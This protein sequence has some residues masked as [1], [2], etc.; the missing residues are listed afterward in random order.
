MPKVLIITYYWPPSGGSSVLRWL[1]FT[2]YLR[3]FGWEPIIYTPDNPE[4]QEIDE[5]LLKDI[6]E[7]VEVIKT[8]IWEPYSIYKWL[9]GRKQSDRLGVALMTNKKSSR[10]FSHISLWIRSNLFIP[11]PRRFWVKPSVRVLGAYL[12]AHPVD[13]IVT[14]G[15]PHTMH[16]IGLGIKKKMGIKWV[17]DFRDPWTNIDFYRDLLLTKAADHYHKKLE[18]EVLKNADCVVTVS[19][20][21]AEELRLLGANRIK[22]ISNGFDYESL[23]DNELVDDGKFTLMHLG[24]IPQSRNPVDLWKVLADLVKM[25]PAFTSCLQIKLI[26]KID[27]QVIESIE[28]NALIEYVKHES[29][30]PHEQTFQQLTSASVLLLLINDTPNAKGILTNKFY[31]YLSAHRP[32]LTLGPA[33]DGDASKILAVTGAGK[34]FKYSDTKGLKSHILT[35]FELYSQHNLKVENNEIDRFSRKNLTRE[36]SELLNELIA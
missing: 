10:L 30:I 34:I 2:K 29:F 1:K 20:S 4:S 13:A 3:E 6:P 31:E 32:I 8:K 16:L 24:S 5:S 22:T 33:D 19:D 14:T 21:W 17:A 35:L 9:T 26:G 11:D 15:P 7:N 18:Q 36:L 27:L 23:S 25:N 12:S 28:Q